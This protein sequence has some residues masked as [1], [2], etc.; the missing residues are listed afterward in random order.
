MVRTEIRRAFVLAASFL[1]ALV[2]T[3]SASSAHAQRELLTPLG[4]RGTLAIDQVSGFRMTG[5]G[6]TGAATYGLAYDGI[7]GFSHQ[8]VAQDSFGTNQTTTAHYTSFWI[9]PSADY[10]VIDHLS[11]G[12]RIELSTTSG[13][14][15]APLGAGNT[16][17][18]TSLPSTTS[19]T[20]LPRIG[21]L[22][23]ISDRFG[24]WPR[25]GLGY[26]THS[27]AVNVA[28]TNVATTDGFSSF[29]IDLDVGFLYRINENWFLRGAPE[30]SLAPGSH[31][32]TQGGTTVS[33]NE[34]VTQ[35]GIVGGIGVMWN[36][37]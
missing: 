8:D 19:V 1:A 34:H 33:A 35:F 10:F 7:I 12:G 29:I 32:V 22:F 4:G 30:L 15:D 25:L 28:N 6:L 5:V 16:T 14:V 27:T 13:S 21:W 17:V 26:G 24:I 18:S 2:V 11:V 20:F 36:L 31:S 3:L 23:A 9:A 37:L